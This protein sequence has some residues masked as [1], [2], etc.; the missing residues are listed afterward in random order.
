MGKE[1]RLKEIRSALRFVIKE[2][3][4]EVLTQELVA[5]AY[6]A[7]TARLE[8]RLDGISAHLTQAIKTIDDRSKDVQSYMIRNSIPHAAVDPAGVD[9]TAG[10]SDGGLQQAGPQAVILPE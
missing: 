10:S 1:S 2:G 7:V 3:M 5:T 4:P 8:Q 6:K 9:L